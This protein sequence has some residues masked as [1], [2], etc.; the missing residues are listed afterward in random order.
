MFVIIFCSL[1][2]LF[3]P[4]L[5]SPSEQSLQSVALLRRTNSFQVG[6]RCNFY[7]IICFTFKDE[8]ER[9][10]HHK[11]FGDRRIGVYGART[12]FY[13][14]SSCNVSNKNCRHY[15]LRARQIAKGTL[16]YSFVALRRWPTPLRY[17]CPCLVVAY[18]EE[19]ISRTFLGEI[20]FR[21][22]SQDR[23]NA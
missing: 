6:Q 22:V 8:M 4:V 2:I 10:Q 3:F 13:Q 21:S 23:M 17:S 7:K 20:Q 9:Y 12:F 1:Q 11:E 5:A 18:T 14:A 19:L 16:R 15:N